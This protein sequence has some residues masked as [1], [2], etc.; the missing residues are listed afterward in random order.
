V[1]SRVL[2]QKKEKEIKENHNDKG[3]FNYT[4]EGQRWHDVT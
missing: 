4:I 1:S 3:K 2:K